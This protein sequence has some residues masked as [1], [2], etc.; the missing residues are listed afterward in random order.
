MEN[1]NS[2][3]KETPKN[4][5]NNKQS[6]LSKESPDQIIDESKEIEDF[7]DEQGLEE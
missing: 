5:T 7:Y 2:N 4:L 1:E 6:E 3:L